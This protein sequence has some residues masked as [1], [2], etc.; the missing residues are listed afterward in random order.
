[1]AKHDES[2]RPPEASTDVHALRCGRAVMELPL[3]AVFAVLAARRRRIL[4]RV[5]HDADACDVADLVEWVAERERQLAESAPD[6]E[7][8]RSELER[9]HLPMLADHRI[10]DYDERNGGVRYYGHPVVEEYL[11]HSADFE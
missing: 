6:R 1:M 9:V 7:T 2:G 4:L 11:E 3:D 5:L 8:L 10:V